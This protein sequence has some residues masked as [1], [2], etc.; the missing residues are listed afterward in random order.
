MVCGITVS[1]RKGAKIGIRAHPWAEVRCERPELLSILQAELLTHSIGSTIVDDR[2]RIQ[3]INNCSMIT[4]FVPLKYEWWNKA[5]VLFVKGEHKHKKGL[6]KILRL[7][8]SGKIPK[9]LQYLNCENTD[10]E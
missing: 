7:R 1:V 6:I 4:P 8:P 2:I 9:N 10:D 3:G 5:I